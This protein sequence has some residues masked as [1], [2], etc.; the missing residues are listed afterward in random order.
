MKGSRGADRTLGQLNRKTGRKI[1]DTVAVLLNTSADVIDLLRREL[2][3]AGIVTFTA[4]T[5]EV[6]DGAVN[7]DDFIGQHDPD[8]IVY[9]IAPP[10]DANWRLFQHLSTRP[11]IAG[12]QFVLTSTNAA[13]VERLVGHD[14][15]VYEVVGKPSDLGCIVR[16][17][18]EAGRVRPL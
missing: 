12:R 9:D 18:K 11:I 8:V 14:R 1:R 6:R 2:E 3:R 7:F 10:Y 5:H 4:F 17:V 13:H 15:R 16:A